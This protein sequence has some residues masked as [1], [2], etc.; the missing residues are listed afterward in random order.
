MPLRCL[1]SI[2]LISRSKVSTKTNELLCN[3][4]IVVTYVEGCVG[5]KII[6][7]PVK[8]HIM[9]RSVTSIMDL[10]FHHTYLGR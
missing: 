9:S 1:L 3:N 2:R 8:G 6:T 5:F 4:R 7:K 10:R